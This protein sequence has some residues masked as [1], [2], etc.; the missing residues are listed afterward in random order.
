MAKN[1][2]WHGE[3]I[4]KK[5]RS[6][7][8]KALGI[9]GAQAVTFVKDL[10]PVG[11]PESTGIKGYAGGLLKSSIAFATTLADAKAVKEEKKTAQQ[12]D[13]ISPPDDSFHLKIGTA[14][15]Y[16]CIFGAHTSINTKNGS[17]TI[18]QI[19]IG[20]EVL[21]Q[22]GEYKK[23]LNKIIQPAIRFP[24]MVDIEIGWRKDKAHK[25][26]VTKDHK[27][28]IFRDGRNKWVKACDL[29][30]SDKLFSQIKTAYNKDTG[31]IK[32][33]I[34]CNN[35]FKGMA[36]KYCSVKCKNVAYR[37]NLNPHLGTK[38]SDKSKQRMS[39]AA[40]KK[41]RD[42]PELH[43]N[44]IMNKKGFKTSVEKQVEQWLTERGIKFI[45]QY[46][47]GKYFIDYYDSENNTAYEAD[48][49]YW[50]SNQTKDI[51][52]DREL[53]L[54]DPTLTIQHIHFHDKRF[55]NIYDI[56]PLKNVY[57][58]VCNPDVNSYA[59]P[60]M[61]EMRKILSLNKWAYGNDLK[62]HGLPQAKVYDLEI[63]D[64]H[65]YYANGILVSNSHVEYGTV[66][67][68]RQSFLRLGILSN[69][70]V[71]GK[72]YAKAMRGLVK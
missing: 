30:M 57:Y 9:V 54:I 17:K 32:T 45:S 28:L 10:T 12:E 69:R 41:F 7:V 5:Y 11:T 53:L 60:E 68:K 29:K 40:E 37:T 70:N 62:K 56:N 35:N 44:R 67:M 1:V 19:K 47:I 2:I 26:T 46:R 15:H 64:V 16:A 63:E 25:L 22:T 24:N 14:V 42:N 20:D 8:P 18:G 65:S 52:R 59:N 27:L 43:P 50:H 66:K 13:L 6:A 48:G 58:T 55:S 49:A 39:R 34:I 31:V 72:L 4:K 23:V 3:R 51:N 33:C 36:K 71:L 38:R 21:T 61:F